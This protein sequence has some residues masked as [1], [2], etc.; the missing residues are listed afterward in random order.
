MK[1]EEVAIQLAEL[2]REF[3][4]SLP[5][6]FERIR[7]LW[8][9]ECSGGASADDQEELRRLI[10]LLAGASGS[11]GQERLGLVALRLELV[12]AEADSRPTDEIRRE[13]SRLIGELE[14]AVESPR[15]PRVGERPA[16]PEPRA[17][18][19]RVAIVEDE[20]ALA[21]ALQSQLASFGYDTVVYGS[22]T[23]AWEGITST[24]PGA[25]ILDLALPEGK[26]AGVS[27]LAD[28]RGHADFDEL[29]VVIVTVRDDVEARDA[30]IRNGASAYLSKPIDL[31]RLVEV[32][33]KL[34][35]PTTEEPYRI[36]IVD[37]DRDL[38]AHYALVLRRA[39]M[40]V[41]TVDEPF[42]VLDRIEEV[43]PDLV[44]VDI[45]MPG[46]EGPGLVRVL[47]HHDRLQGLSIV[48]ISTEAD[49]EKQLDALEMGGDD[50]IT[51]PIRDRHLVAMVRLKARRSRTLAGLMNRDGLTGLLGHAPLKERLRSELANAQRSA[52]P[53]CFALLDVDHFKNVNDTFGHLEGDRVL[54][55]LAQLLERRVRTGDA[56]GR[57]G[58]EEFALVLPHCSREDGVALVE[59]LRCAFQGVTFRLG[60]EDSVSLTFSAGVS[61]AR[62][63]EVTIAALIERAD[64]ALYVA[65]ASGR[66]RVVADTDA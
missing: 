16:K 2:R 7:D 28:L 15:S 30:A 12:F 17:D 19:P 60:G 45:K 31:V 1:T 5:A 37:D 55:T 27:L 22:R 62:S 18:A 34:C 57:Y 23:E 38:A 8:E 65:K 20:V 66:N 3:A 33:D 41:S 11:F 24:P 58:G 21:A 50:F 39:G 9:R 52:T 54:R 6:R 59:E 43:R 13:I 61:A 25:V 14:E 35:R 49:L 47:R 44:L 40:E 63:D 51:K 26:L 64:R 29:P 56:V 42:E 10:H 32:L 46:I 36:L 4:A 48:Y 53:V